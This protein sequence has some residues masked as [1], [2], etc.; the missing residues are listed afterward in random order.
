MGRRGSPGDGSL[1]CP[2]DDRL[3]S[4]RVAVNHD[5]DSDTT[6]SL[7]GPLPGAIQGEPAL[8][9]WLHHL[10]LRETITEIADDLSHS[11]AWELDQ[12]ESGGFTEKIWDRSQGGSA[13]QCERTGVPIVV[14][15]G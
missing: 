3:C 1:L 14:S 13:R 5:G 10:E 15:A 4:C 8:P 11:L 6:G 12:D 9:P 7:V 2:D